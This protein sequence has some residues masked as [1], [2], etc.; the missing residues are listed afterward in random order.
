MADAQI[1]LESIVQRRRAARVTAPEHPVPAE[2]Q[3][4]ILITYETTETAV[5]KALDA[6]KSDG[7]IAGDP[8]LIRIE[9]LA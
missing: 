9:P 7:H 3:P 5:R 1:S 4:V 2:P 6:I 8:Q